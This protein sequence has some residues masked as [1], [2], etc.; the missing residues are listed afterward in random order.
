MTSNSTIRRAVRLAL[1]SGAATTAMV[2]VAAVAQ[3]AQ[4]ASTEVGTIVVTGTRIQRADYEAT[5]PVVT[6]SSELLQQSGSVQLDTF[7]NQLPQL[8]P[9]L[10]TTSN[11]PS[12]NGGAG[13][14]LINLRGLGVE[15]TLVLLDGT[16]LMPTYTTGQIDLNQVP[17]A[18]IDNIEIL[19]GGAS[20]VYGSDAIAGVVNVKLKKQ[21]EGVQFDAHYGETSDSDGAQNAFDLTM[22]GNFADGRGNAVLAFSYDDRDAVFQGDREFSQS[23]LGPDLLPLGSGTVPDGKYTPTATNLPSQA[24]IDAAFATYGVAAGTVTPGGN[25]GFNTDGTLFGFT[26]TPNYKGEQFVGFNPASYS[27]N[28]APVNYLQLPL[29]R[30]Q[31][32]AFGTFNVAEMETASVEAYARMIYSTY[33]A[34]SQLAATPV[35][36][37]SVPVTNPNIPADLQGIL[38]SRP[39]PGDPFVFAIRTLAVGER[40][41]DN[42]YDVLQGLAGLRGDFQVGERRYNWDFSGSWGQTNTTESQSGNVSRSRLQ[43]LLDGVDLDT[44]AAASFNPFG[45]GNITQECSNAIAIRTTNVINIEQQTLSASLTGDLFEMPAGAFQFAVGAE[46]MKTDATFRPDEF[47][48]SGVVVG[49]NA[50]PPQAGETEIKEGYVELAIPLLKD[51]PG[52]HKMGL[53]LGY[54]YSD[55][56]LAGTYDTYK[57]ALNWDFT[58]TF[59]FRGSYNRAVR[60]P[61]IY[62]LFLPPQENFPVAGDPCNAPQ[63]SAEVQNLCI[64]QGIPASVLPTFHQTNPQ[65]RAIEG[66]NQNLDPESAD[67]YTAGL[68]WQP[69]FANSA[70][71]T[72]IDYWQYEISDTIGTVSSDSA[73]NRCFNDVGANPTFDPN[74]QWC[75]L[76]FRDATAQITDV[77]ENFQNL[78]KLKA[79][80]VDLQIDYGQPISDKWGRLSVNLLVTNVIDWDSQEDSASPFGHFAGTITTDVGESYPEWKGVLNLGWDIGQFG[81][82]YQLRYIDSLTVVHNDAVGSP[83]VDGLKPTVPS[84]TYSRITAR[85]SPTETID[86]MLGIDNVF[87]KDPPIFTDDDQAGQQANT[88]PTLYDVLGRRYYGN[89]RFKF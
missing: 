84:Y 10:S 15:R 63:A 49:F 42:K 27:Y 70:F 37:L 1:A 89:V 3:E 40:V 43:G 31:V 69:A 20:S 50:Q 29:T 6:V 74:N 62:E 60:A 28:F 67:T 59:R 22:G 54:R 52:I 2:G 36:G 11:N 14:A 38:A 77:Q 71:R 7:L 5:S 58:E 9:S 79:K 85:W 83:V 80:G 39:T 8:V 47:L 44:C 76:F 72:S 13:Q 55:H 17:S 18:L 4:D 65:V 88:D 41:S 53:E 82:A 19:T 81:F 30:R 32:A 23:S 75:Q 25:L 56:N 46:Y 48:A 78:G 35:T 57:G 61:S 64:A 51:I 86:V 21:F 87:D 24:A 33:E 68:V 34:S 16:R 45:L 26:G 73:I 12:A 66:G